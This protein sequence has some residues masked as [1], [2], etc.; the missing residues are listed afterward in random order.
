MWKNIKMIL[1][2]VLALAPQTLSAT[3]ATAGIDTKDLNSL[4][5]LIN[6][7]SFAFD[8]TNYLTVNLQH[9]DTDSSYANVGQ[10]GVYDGNTAPTVL[11]LNDQAT[12]ESK[13]HLV[14]YRGGKRFVRL[15]IVESGTVSAPISV[16]A[17]SNHSELLPPL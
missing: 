10:D 5:F 13:S 16:V 17:I 7:G 15:N 4:A 6:V 1:K 11:V 9:S 3:T 12:Q 8:G 14:E 2:H